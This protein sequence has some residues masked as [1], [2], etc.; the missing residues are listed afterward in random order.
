MEEEINGPKF[1]A[2]RSGTD[3]AKT[4]LTYDDRKRKN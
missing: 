1:G 2:F 3:L 4:N